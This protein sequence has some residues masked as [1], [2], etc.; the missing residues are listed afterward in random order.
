MRN[1]SLACGALALAVMVLATPAAADEWFVAGQDDSAVLLVNRSSIQR[2]GQEIILS[3][4]AVPPAGA[5]KR[6]MTF[7]YRISSWSVNCTTMGAYLRNQSDFDAYESPINYGVP[8]IYPRPVHV[9]LEHDT[10]LYRAAS[11]ACT[12]QWGDASPMA[13]RRQAYQHG[14]GVVTAGQ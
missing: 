4:M 11:M 5:Q 10:D 12:D 14:L 7:I 8:Q 9:P 1:K 6:G 13:T 2:N 3:T